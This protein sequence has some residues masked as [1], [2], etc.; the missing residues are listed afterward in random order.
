[1]NQTPSNIAR[2]ELLG[3]HAH[4]IESTDHGQLSHQGEVID[5]SREMLHLKTSR[6]TVRVPKNTS[7][8]DFSLPDGSVVRV[9]GSILIGRPEDRMKK[10]LR[11]SLWK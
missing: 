10:R 8:F 2:H 9:D 1:M 5:E 11:R 3:L 7:V 4:V 6:G